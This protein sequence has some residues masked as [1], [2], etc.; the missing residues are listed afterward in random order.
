MVGPRAPRS[1]AAASGPLRRRALAWRTRRERGLDGLR[2]VGCAA[3]TFK[4]TDQIEGHV[5]ELGPGARLVVGRAHSDPPPQI[6]VDDPRVSRVHCELVGAVAGIQVFDH[7]TYG[8]YIN[9][10]K[11][12]VQALASHGDLVQLGAHYAFK[13]EAADRPPGIPERFGE[14]YPYVRFIAQGGMGVVVEVLDEETGLPRAVKVLRGSKVGEEQVARFQREIEVGQKLA[15]HPGIVPVLDAGALPTGE[16]F[17]VMEL[18]EGEEFSKRIVAGI[19]RRA[20]VGLVVEIA[21]AVAH[22]HALGVIH[23]DLKPQNVIV[24]SEGRARLTDFGVAKAR[25]E[26]DNLTATGAVMGTMTYMSPEQVEDSKRVD[27]RTDVYGLGAILYA[28]LTCLPPI[29]LRGLSMRKSLDKVLAHEVIPPRG[30]DSS[31]DEALDGICMKAIAR[32]PADRYPSAAEL[33]E[34]LEAWLRGE[35]LV[36][37][38]G[39]FSTQM[40]PEDVVESESSGVVLLAMLILGLLLFVGLAG[41]AI[42]G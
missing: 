13:V 17:C 37:P 4:L 19:E 2:A 38:P 7:S 27:E 8:T 22:A 36:P 16:L 21:R 23:R 39:S 10:K 25:D 42:F 35:A 15:D 1:G 14:R 33:A 20:A 41:F 26:N 34:A 30:H 29:D 18:V 32:L 5:Y 12:E 40:S 9:G 6:P 31:I 3:V 28:A 11:V 24:T